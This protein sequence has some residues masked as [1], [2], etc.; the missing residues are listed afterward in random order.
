MAASIA[1]EEELGTCTG[2]AHPHNGYYAGDFSRA[3]ATTGAQVLSILVRPQRG[4][5][6]AEPAPDARAA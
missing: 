3:D 5:R 4:S 1:I 6:T 2:F